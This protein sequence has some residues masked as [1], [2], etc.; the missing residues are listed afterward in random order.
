MLTTFPPVSGSGGTV[1]T[2]KY[3]NVTAVPTTIGGVTAGTT[4]SAKTM[5]EMWNMLLYPYQSPAFISFTSDMPT[6]LEIGDSIPA[7]TKTFSWAT[8][9]SANIKPNI[10]SITYGSALGSTLAN[11]G[12]EALNVAMQ[13][14]TTISNHTFTIS[15][16]NTNNVTFTRNLTVSWRAP[17]WYGESALTTLTGTDVV[18]LRAKNLVTSPNGNYS[19]LAGGYKWICY[20]V[21]LGL[22]TVFK[23]TSTNF[24][25]AM[26]PV[27]TVSVTNS[28]GVTQN[29]YCH[30]TYNVLGGSIT[31][32]VS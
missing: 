22:K 27:E 5:T 11:D 9:N 16:Q 10:I 19:V 21:S 15:A 28:F 30:R 20:P 7:G 2:E 18:A 13:I 31:I 1:T 6:V 23:D 25:V 14:E 29:Y 3:T 32:G 12:S 24:D 4:F 26:N 17:V 8:S